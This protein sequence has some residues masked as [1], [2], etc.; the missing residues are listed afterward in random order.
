MRDE[1][2]TE[3]KPKQERQRKKV[4]AADKAVWAEIVAHN[5]HIASRAM[6]IHALIEADPKAPKF[7]KLLKNI[8][9]INDRA[10]KIEALGKEVND[11]KDDTAEKESERL[12]KQIADAQA[13]LAEL[14]GE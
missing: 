7:N 10:E 2:K 13:K 1:K 11:W 12:K 3:D 8:L 14:S 6:D 4:T 9:A 5:Q